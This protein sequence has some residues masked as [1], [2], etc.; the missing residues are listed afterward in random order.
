MTLIYP[1]SAVISPHLLKLTFILTCFLPRNDRMVLD[2]LS[3]A[4]TRLEGAVLGGLL[5]ATYLCYWLFRY[6]HVRMVG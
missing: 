2:Q 5:V 6:I 1:V 4:V 3:T